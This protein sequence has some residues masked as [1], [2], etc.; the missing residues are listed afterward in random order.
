MNKYLHGQTGTDGKCVYLFVCDSEDRQ[1]LWFH[2]SYRLLSVLFHFQ[3]RG[4]V[5]LFIFG[6][7]HTHIHAAMCDSVW[8]C[9]S[10]CVI[11]APYK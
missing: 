11:F 10:E 1:Q 6:N 3:T 9:V 8:V 7:T 4:V 5:I 2:F